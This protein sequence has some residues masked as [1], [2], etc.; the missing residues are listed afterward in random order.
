MSNATCTDNSLCNRYTWGA[1]CHQVVD[2]EDV[3][4][5]VQVGWGFC[6]SCRACDCHRHPP[7][8]AERFAKGSYGV[9]GVAPWF[10]SFTCKALANFGKRLSLVLLSKSGAPSRRR[11]ASDGF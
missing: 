8:C 3:A 1:C 9:T 6:I 4:G 10:T 2:E 7:G 11:S 5:A